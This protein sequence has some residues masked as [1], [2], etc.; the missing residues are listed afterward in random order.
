MLIA[1]N[2]LEFRQSSEL[3]DELVGYSVQFSRVRILQRVLKLGAADAVFHGEVLHR[4]HVQRNAFDLSQ[5][6]LQAA[7]D[8]GSSRFTLVAG[9]QINLNSAAVRGEIGA[10]YSN[11]RR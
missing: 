7:D 4:L 9:F 2:I 3:I 8:V 6:G 11:K 10:V 5:L 1:G